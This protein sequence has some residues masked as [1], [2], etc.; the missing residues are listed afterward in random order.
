MRR[1][2]GKACIEENC[3]D[4][5]QDESNFSGSW[6]EDAAWPENPEEAASY[7]SDCRN[8][9]LPLT[10][11]GGLTG[12]AAG[13]LPDGGAVISTSMMKGLSLEGPL[14]RAEAGV[15]IDELRSFLNDNIPGSF[16]PPNPTEETA[17]LGGTAATDASGSDSYLYG[18]TRRWVR[19]LELILPG[20]RNLLLERGEYGFAGD[21]TCMHPE[22]G[23]L[24]L[25]RLEHIQPPK[26]AAGYWLHPG[27]DLIDLF[28]GS[29]G[30][31]GLI[32]AVWIEP[33]PRPA[34]TVDLAVFPTCREAFWSLFEKLTGSEQAMR[35]RAVEMMDDRC[36]AF[37][38]E[39]PGDLPEPPK[40]ADSALILRI[41]AMDDN[42]LDDVLMELDGMMED[43][44]IA[45]D[46]VWGGFDPPEQKRIR[47]FRHALPEAVNHA[48]SASKRQY[49][50]IHKLGS[51]GAVAP[52]LLQ[53]Y[54]T[55]IRHLL[56]KAGLPFVIFGHAGQGHL[57]ANAIPTAPDELRSAEKSM[58]EIAALS[59]SL[60]GT[61]SAE[62]GL[63]RLKSE[64][65]AM[66]YSEAEL[67]GMESLRETIDPDGSFMPAISFR[68]GH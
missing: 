4:I 18:A 41:E 6:C 61:V 26:N 46:T 44:S 60:G 11:S 68:G 29:E 5:L 64:F 33:A 38:R 20:G 65:L 23:L 43:L 19:K 16:Y 12:I 67:A 62:H 56:E 59:V 52:S 17:T 40:G 10:V 37:I 47:D 51:D 13:A 31:L 3:A 63:G 39:H 54:Y 28:I 14:V 57:H 21:M 49:P 30:T 9:G 22:I 15:T 50:D 58:Q 32:T 8:A 27:M 53:S 45:P 42:A 66:M 48:I 36:M 24:T 34:H 2:I 1:I 35:V 25:P 55:D 7:I